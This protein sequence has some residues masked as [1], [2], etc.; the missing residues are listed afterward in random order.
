MAIIWWQRKHF[1][2]FPKQV[3]TFQLKWKSLKPAKHVVHLNLTQ[4]RPEETPCQCWIKKTWSDRALQSSVTCTLERRLVVLFF[5]IASFIPPYGPLLFISSQSVSTGQW[6]L[7]ISL[8]DWTRWP[9]ILSETQ[10]HR[11]PSQPTHAIMMSCITTN[12]KRMCVHLCCRLV[13]WVCLARELQTVWDYASSVPH[14]L[15][16]NDRH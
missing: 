6:L 14:P 12:S 2:N 3:S 10:T 9:T 4:S 7:P 8:S 15:D 16:M 11:L 5:I 1:M 13:L